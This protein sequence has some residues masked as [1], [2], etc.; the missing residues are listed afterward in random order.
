MSLDMLSEGRTYYSWPPLIITTEEQNQCNE[1]T[2][3]DRKKDND[4]QR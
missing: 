4:S 2:D 3:W 1:R